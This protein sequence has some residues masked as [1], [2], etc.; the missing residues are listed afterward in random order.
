MSTTV[1]YEKPLEKPQSK[2]CLICGS[3][4]IRMSLKFK[5]VQG[6][7]GA[8]IQKNGKSF[9]NPETWDGTNEGWKKQK[10]LM[11]VENRARKSPRADWRLIIFEPLYDAVYQRQGKSNW[12]MIK[13]GM[14][15]A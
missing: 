13:K 15:F 8:Y 4:S 12:V 6:F 1:K 10:T 2:G 7:G 3:L 9:Y 11:W 14:G 5:I